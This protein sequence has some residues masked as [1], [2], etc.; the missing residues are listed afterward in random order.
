[1]ENVIGGELEMKG[2]LEKRLQKYCGTEPYEEITKTLNEFWGEQLSTAQ[3]YNYITISM[4]LEILRTRYLNKQDFRLHKEPSEL[5][6]FKPEDVITK[7]KAFN[8]KWFGSSKQHEVFKKLFGE[9][10]LHKNALP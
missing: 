5:K 9:V 10:P 1:L 4:A 2:K 6:N 3:Y 7:Y 8:L